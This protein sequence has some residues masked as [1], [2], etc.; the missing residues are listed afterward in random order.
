MEN[1]EFLCANAFLSTEIDARAIKSAMDLGVL[2]ALEVDA[3]SLS[4]ISVERQV[5]LRGLQ[6]LVDMLETNG[7][8]VRIGDRIAL[9]S[10]FRKALRFRDLLTLRIE[11]ADLVWT[12]IHNLFTP[13]LTDLPQFMA[14]S[15]IFDLFRYDRCFDLTPE[16]VRATRTWTRFTTCLTKYEAG[17][18]LDAID[19]ESVG[20]FIDLGGNT[21]EFAFQACKRSPSLTATVVDLPV[22]CEIGRRHILDVG[23][24]ETA[25]RVTFFPTDMRTGALPNAADLVSFKSV[26]HDWPDE[27]AVRLLERA[28]QLVRPGGRLLIFEREPIDIRGRR[29]SYAMTPDL[30]F[31]H[32]LRPA[33]LYLK[34]LAELGFDAIE[35]RSIALDVGFHL[36]TARRPPEPAAPQSRD[37]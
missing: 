30:A 13:L 21:G 4:Q 9:T 16:N 17:A 2:D 28:H 24:P 1:I 10:E 3:A 27:D 31:L 12:D 8:V 25:Q 33:D 20:T 29:I 37:G 6:L 23:G 22:V 26:L 35:H 18:A 34:K 19:L 5:N 7:V 11:F 15:K 14:R 36:I 32:F